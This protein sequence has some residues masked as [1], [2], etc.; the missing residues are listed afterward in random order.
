[1]IN[2]SILP[3]LLSLVTLLS[4]PLFQ[5]PQEQSVTMGTHTTDLAIPLI[6][7]SLCF[8]I[9][10]DRSTTYHDVSLMPAGI[11]PSQYCINPIAPPFYLT[12]QSNSDR[13][14]A[15]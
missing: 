3:V 4:R 13:G 12:T 7:F 8:C 2:A 6:D 5:S 10:H 15:G 11:L 14:R 1:M 9:L